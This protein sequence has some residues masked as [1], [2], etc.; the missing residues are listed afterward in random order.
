MTYDYFYGQQA[1][2]FAFYRVPKVLFTEDCFWNVS[3]DAKLLYGILLD[4]MNLSA[5]NGWLDEE[6][7]VYIIFTIEEIKGLLVEKKQAYAEYRQVKKE[8]QEYLIAK[9]TVEHILGIDRHKRVEEKKQQ[10]EEQR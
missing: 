3:T 1:E 5:R 10:K 2:M 9:Q 4:R 8:M 7:R 6:G